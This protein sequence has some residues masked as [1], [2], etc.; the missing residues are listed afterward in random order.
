MALSTSSIS[1]LD[2]FQMPN[3]GF[4]L[5]EPQHQPPQPQQHFNQFQAQPHQYNNQMQPIQVATHFGNQGNNQYGN[6]LLQ[7]AQTQQGNYNQGNYNNQPQY[8]QTYSKPMNDYNQQQNNQYPS[9]QYQNQN[10]Q[11]QERRYSNQMQQQQQQ[12]Q[13]NQFKNLNQYSNQQPNQTQ[14]TNQNQQS[15]SPYG[16]QPSRP[17]ESFSNGGDV[18]SHYTNMSMNT[19][20][21]PMSGNSAIVF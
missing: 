14:Y 16:A 6:H 8:N 3:N 9:Q 7:Q 5:H 2:S 11:Y 19:N 12:Q 13:Q 4:V 17:Y 18:T 20:N 21:R 15:T 1:F 10:Q